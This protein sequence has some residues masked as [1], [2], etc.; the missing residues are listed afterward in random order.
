MN[1][2]IYQVDSF[3][4]KP[5][6]GNPAGVCL[7]AAPAEAAWMQSVAR[8]MNLSETAF[9]V[10]QPDGFNLRWFTPAAEVRLCGHA[11][12]ASAHILWETKTLRKEEQA[13]FHTLSGLLTAELCGDWIEMDFPACPPKPVQ[14]PAGL[15][16]ALGV[17]ARFIGRDVDDYLVEV[18][19]E[20]VVRS[21]MPDITML[22]KLPVRGTIVTARSGNPKFDFVSRF[23]APA[24]GVNEDPVTG[25]AHCC[26]TPYWSEKLGKM[27]MTAFQASARGGTVRVRMA[28]ER[29]RIC[30]E[31]V[32]V[33][34]CELA[35]ATT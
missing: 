1:Q 22:G 33:M 26:L 35:L 4:D 34:T 17:E 19:S 8:E 10:Q 5:F 9:L 20:E 24:V 30:G 13:R 25:S 27:E 3:T 18:E 6:A 2:I 14:P 28:G 12:L 16:A 15:T 7:L 29:V 31:A 21:L 11:T 32:T 23:F